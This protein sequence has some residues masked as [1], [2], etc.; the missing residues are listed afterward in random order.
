LAA[1]CASLVSGC[2]SAPDKAEMLV[3]TSPPGA[4]CTLVQ[5]ARTVATAAPTPAIAMVEPGGAAVTVTCRREGYA[6]GT[7][8]VPV[9]GT[10]RDFYAYVFG[11]PAPEAQARADIVLVPK[12]HG[13]AWP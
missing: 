2:A 6:D 10:S 1:V 11:Q 13:A 3:S 5:H 4:A 8:T 7:V 9:S 12:S